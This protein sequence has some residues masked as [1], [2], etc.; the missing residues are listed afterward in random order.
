MKKEMFS[1]C[2]MVPIISFM[3]SF[4]CASTEKATSD[5]LTAAREQTQTIAETI[6]G[7]ELVLNDKKVWLSDI[8]QSKYSE[9]MKSGILASAVTIEI[10]KNSIP[11]KKGEYVKF[12]TQFNYITEAVLV[13]DITIHTGKNDVSLKADTPISFMRAFSGD[14]Y[15]YSGYLVTDTEL[16]IGTYRVDAAAQGNKYIRDILFGYKGDIAQVI[17]KTDHTFIIKDE[18]YTFT[19]GGRLSFINEN[20]SGGIL[21][22]NRKVKIGKY[23]VT[24]LADSSIMSSLN[25]TEDGNIFMVMVAEPVSIKVRAQTIPLEA[26]KY[27][28]FHYNTDN[29]HFAYLGKDISLTVSGEKKAFKAGTKLEFDREGAIIKAQE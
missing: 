21:K 7:E 29:P 26:K 11:L 24:A 3:L 14:L 17:L 12:N 20:V 19:K 23:E 9:T 27:L 5:S 13:E 28:T 10:G 4:S 1:F 2:I 16:M 8:E 15:I 25:F 6:E 22:D 18:R